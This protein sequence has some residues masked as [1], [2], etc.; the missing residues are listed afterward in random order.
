MTTVIT[1]VLVIVAVYL[2]LAAIAFFGCAIQEEFS[3]YAVALSYGT[4]AG[5][6]TVVATLL[7]FFGPESANAAVNVVAFMIVGLLVLT[8]VFY[9]IA[10]AG[11]P[12]ISELTTNPLVGEPPSK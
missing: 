8:G 12:K 6:L 2:V 9:G 11:A 7:Y 4:V 10:E 5:V 3:L 1:I